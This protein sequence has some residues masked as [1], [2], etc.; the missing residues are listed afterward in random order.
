MENLK[1]AN[2]IYV[3][4]NDIVVAL[5]QLDFVKV[6]GGHNVTEFDGAKLKNLT[7][8]G[9]GMPF[10]VTLEIKEHNVDAKLLNLIKKKSISCVLDY[11]LQDGERHCVFIDRVQRG[12]AD[13]GIIHTPWI[14]CIPRI[15]WIIQTED[16]HC[17]NS[18]GNYLRYPEIDTRQ[19][20]NKVFQ[21][22]GSSKCSESEYPSA[23]VNMFPK[24][25]NGLDRTLWAQL[26]GL[27]VAFE[28]DNV[29]TDTNPALGLYVVV[30][31]SSFLFVL[32]CAIDGHSAFKSNSLEQNNKN[33]WYLIRALLCPFRL[34]S[35]F[36][37]LGSV[38]VL[39]ENVSLKLL[40]LAFLFQLMIVFVVELGSIYKLQNNN[41]IVLEWGLQFSLCLVLLRD[42][43]L[44]WLASLENSQKN[45]SNVTLSNTTLSNATLSNAQ[46]CRNVLESKVETFCQVTIPLV[47][48]SVKPSFYVYLIFPQ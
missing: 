3:G 46:D 14:P 33:K 41:V 25:Y 37:L 44:L 20:G 1:K 11:I 29:M 5:N 34:L 17:I 8:K 47:I 31:I 12:E 42:I 28:L 9:T 4:L 39:I 45:I 38:L 26:I 16:F 18:W 48:M 13:I 19:V 21:V 32:L 30:L 23:K 27:S 35:A 36:I 6:K 22:K 24:I 40:P 43:A 10:D 15:L 2:N 7:D